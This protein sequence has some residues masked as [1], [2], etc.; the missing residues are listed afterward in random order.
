MRALAACAVALVT[1]A[2]RSAVAFTNVAVGQPIR[3]RDLAAATANVPLLGAGRAS[4]FVMFRSDAESS[5][6]ALRELSLVER[7]LDGKGVSFVAV[8]PGSDDLEKAKAL[9]LRSGARMPLLVDA[10]DA[11]HAELGVRMHPVIGV[12]D[13]RKRLS[14]YEHYRKLGFRQIVRGRIAVAIGEMTPAE[15]EQVLSPPDARIAD[16]LS[17]ARRQ[18]ALGG[19]ELAR[20]DATK[21]EASARKAVDHAPAWAPGHALLGKALAA[22]G[23]CKEAT[24]AFEEAL[25]LAPADAEA[26]EGLRACAGR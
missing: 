20:G 17:R 4:V 7:E 18:V 1:L 14:A 19:K 11:L 15:M 5:Y 16:E 12:V 6:D 2:P 23:R 25:R 10:G 21:A 22:R 8:V 26:K 9:L 24:A 13:A 3:D